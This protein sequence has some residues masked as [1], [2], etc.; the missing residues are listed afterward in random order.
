MKTKK[1]RN[2]QSLYIIDKTDIFLR[3]E[4]IQVVVILRNN[5]SKKK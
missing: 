1:K 3:R 5:Y 4:D 2:K